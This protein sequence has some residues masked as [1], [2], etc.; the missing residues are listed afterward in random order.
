LNGDAGGGDDGDDGGGV[1][2]CLK[3]V[4]IGVVGVVGVGVGVLGEDQSS[5]ICC[6]ACRSALAFLAATLRHSFR[7]A[8]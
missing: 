8:S 5:I 2:G 6:E 4:A 3:P 7:H 1:V